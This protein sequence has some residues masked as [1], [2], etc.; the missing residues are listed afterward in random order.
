MKKATITNKNVTISRGAKLRRTIVAASA[1]AMAGG[2]EPMYFGNDRG[3]DNVP[4]EIYL[5]N[6]ARFIEANFSEPLTQYAIGWRD[7]GKLEALLE[8]MA[9]KVPTSRRFEFAKATNAE[10]FMSETDDLRAIGSDFKRIEYT[11]DKQTDKTLNKGLT[12]RV[13]MDNVT[14]QPNWREQYTGRIMRR[15]LRNECRRSFALLDAAA[16]A[17][18][19]QAWSANFNLDPDQTVGDQV[20]AFQ[21]IAGIAPSRGLFGVKAWQYRRR[22]FRA[23]NNAGGF[24]S[25]KMNEQEVAD[26]LGLDSVMV[27]RERY[28]SSAALKSKIIGDSVYLYFA[29]ANQTNEDPSN[30]KRFV[31]PTLGGTPFRVYE[32]QVNA[33]LIDITVE[34]YSNIVVCSTLGIQKIPIV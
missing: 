25:A 10:E 28:Q 24:A 32:Q 13:D 9:P 4:G 27:S 31:S 20:I 19:N 33:K 2:D 6:A 15:L 26:F 16:T 30:I 3:A 1:L 5:A 7:P 14:E 17:T 23:Q 12:I 18:G 11:S 29:E 34:H 8:F 21:D 22:C